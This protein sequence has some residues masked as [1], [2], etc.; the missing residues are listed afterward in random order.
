MCLDEAILFNPSNL[1]TSQSLPS[2]QKPNQRGGTHCFKVNL[3]TYLNVCFSFE[4]R[5]LPKIELEEVEKFV[6]KE[7]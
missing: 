3:K 4:N 2:L 1:F 6:K 5:F 7:L